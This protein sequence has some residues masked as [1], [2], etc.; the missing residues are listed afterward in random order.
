MY[1]PLQE[2]TS[3]VYARRLI[4]DMDLAVFIGLLII[5]MTIPGNGIIITGLSLLQ[6]IPIG[7]I[8]TLG[9]EI[10]HWLPVVLSMI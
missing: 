5:Y 3:A 8:T 9:K 10:V 7:K 4:K 6:G 1:I 2:G